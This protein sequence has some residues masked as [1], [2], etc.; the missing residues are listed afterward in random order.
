MYVSRLSFSTIPGKGHL[1][2]EQLQSLVELI[3]KAGSSRPRVLRTH[4]ASLG[5]ADIQLEQE[6]KTLSDLETQLQKVTDNEQFRQWSESFSQLL[7]RSPQ[8]EIF[9]VVA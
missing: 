2:T 8:R 5:E 1:A 3:A 4:F 7:L 6:F 9:E